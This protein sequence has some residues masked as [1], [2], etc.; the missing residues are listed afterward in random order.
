MKILAFLLIGILLLGCVQ[1]A[2]TKTTPEPVS[3]NTGTDNN[4]ILNETGNSSQAFGSNKT[5]TANETLNEINSNES[6]LYS[7]EFDQ[8]LSDL[9]RVK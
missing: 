1:K 8:M 4:G 5:A 2:E 7:D 3:K 6:D 9:D